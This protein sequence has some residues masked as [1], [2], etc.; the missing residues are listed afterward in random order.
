MT[1]LSG[2]VRVVTDVQLEYLLQKVLLLLASMHQRAAAGRSPLQL[3]AAAAAMLDTLGSIA[4]CEVEG[5]F[6]NLKQKPTSNTNRLS[7]AR[8]AGCV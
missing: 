6:P 8:N 5:G 3:R 7:S 1:S 4:S 2:K